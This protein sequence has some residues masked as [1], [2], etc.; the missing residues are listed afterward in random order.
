VG[1]AELR[2]FRAQ[3]E[4]EHGYDFTSMAKTVRT[5]PRQ[6]PFFG[7]D[8]RATAPS[9]VHANGSGRVIERAIPGGGMNSQLW[10]ASDHAEELSRRM[11]DPD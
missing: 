9:R 8:G 6:R 1:E 7:G 4:D 10:E 11:A 5:G 2:E 3:G